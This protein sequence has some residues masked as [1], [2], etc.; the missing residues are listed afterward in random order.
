MYMDY[1][2]LKSFTLSNGGN[3]KTDGKKVR[4]LGVYP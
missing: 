3:M 2:G 1:L 4:Q